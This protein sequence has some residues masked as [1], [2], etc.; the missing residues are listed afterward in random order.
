M[1]IVLTVVHGAFISV[2]HPWFIAVYSC[3]GC[4]LVLNLQRLADGR[5]EMLPNA[6]ASSVRTHTL[7]V[8]TSQI[9]IE[10]PPA[11]RV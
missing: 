4:R 6:G 11:S 8:I 7:P 3:A 5:E 9:V 1:S 10:P 2:L